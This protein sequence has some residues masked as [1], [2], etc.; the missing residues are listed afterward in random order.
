MLVTVVL[1]A[2]RLPKSYGAYSRP[3]GAIQNGFDLGR[4]ATAVGF[5]SGEAAA[6]RWDTD[7][8]LLPGT[9]TVRHSIQRRKGA[10][11]VLVPPESSEGRRTIELPCVC[12][13]GLKRHREV[14]E[15]ERV[16]GGSRW[17][18]SGHVFTC[19]IGTP[20]NDRKILGEFDKLVR[21]AGLRK[22][23][24]HDLRH[25]VITLLAA[26]GVPLKVIA[27]IVGHSDIRLTQNVYQPAPTRWTAFLRTWRSGKMTA[28]L[29]RLLPRSDQCR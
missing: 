29:P 10:G 7:V 5:W 1:F 9:I 20:T 12:V 2:A 24:V 16:L 8:D 26:Q 18:E 23:R 27:D 22:Q 6:L 13:S 28:L 14:Q 21:G 11:L 4:H 25:L 15:S 3:D 19:S 17:A